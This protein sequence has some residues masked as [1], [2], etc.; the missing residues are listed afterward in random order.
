MLSFPQEA[1]STIGVIPQFKSIYSSVL[2]IYRT[3]DT[4]SN[5][6]RGSKRA[7]L[8]THSPPNH[9]QPVSR[10]HARSPRPR[11]FD[12]YKFLD[13]FLKSSFS[14]FVINLLLSCPQC[15]V[16]LIN[17]QSL[18]PRGVVCRDL[19]R[20]HHRRGRPIPS[21]CRES[22]LSCG[23]R[24]NRIRCHPGTHSTSSSVSF[25]AATLPSLLTARPVRTSVLRFDHTHLRME[26]RN[27]GLSDGNPQ[28]RDTERNTVNKG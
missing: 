26:L 9:A 24:Q 12:K 28:I 7:T 13:C 11:A 17:R 18:R 25:I 19:R 16:L 14:L 5:A 3:A 27:T 23:W 20:A 8:M 4:S 15:I 6:T 2:I 1:I 21:E 22:Y 10:V